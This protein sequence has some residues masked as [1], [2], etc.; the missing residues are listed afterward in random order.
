[1]SATFLLNSSSESVMITPGYT[2]RGMSSSPSVCAMT[3]A[4]VANAPE[5]IATVGIPDRSTAAQARSTAGVQLPQAPTPTTAASTRHSRR[6][7]LKAAT[8][9]F[10]S[11]AGP[12]ILPKTSWVTTSKPSADA[13]V[14]LANSANIHRRGTR[15]PIQT[16]PACRRSARRGAIVP[17]SCCW[18]STAKGRHTEV[19]AVRSSS[20]LLLACSL[21]WIEDIEDLYD[22]SITLRPG[23][24]KAGCPARHRLDGLVGEGHAEPPAVRPDARSDRGVL[25][26]ARDP[27]AAVGHLA[28]RERDGGPT[29][30]QAGQGHGVACARDGWFLAR[31]EGGSGN[32]RVAGGAAA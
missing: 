11:S 25:C 22:L 5:T 32:R 1:M 4:I 3:L 20:R 7:S 10:S 26:R 18:D 17:P 2:A 8:A 19:P 28:D 30:R 15:G 31:S 13:R 14:R 9:C 21:S 23:R 12:W 24:D 16:P 27:G 6:R 29:A